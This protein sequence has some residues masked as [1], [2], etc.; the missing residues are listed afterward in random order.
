MTE[1]KKIAKNLF[2]LETAAIGAVVL[3]YGIILYYIKS[4]ISCDEGYYLMGYIKSQEL[5]PMA[6]DF[7]NMVRAIT[8]DGM[9]ENVLYFRYLRFFLDIASAL[10]FG[11]SSFYWLKKEKNFQ[12]SRFLYIPLII[13]SA[14]IGYT[15]TTATISFDHLQHIIYLFAFSAFLYADASGNKTIRIISLCIAGFFVVLG[16]TNYLP[17]GI[18]LLLVFVALI[19]I[20]RQNNSAISN[21]F[22]LFGGILIGF[23]IYHFFVTPVDVLVENIATSMKVAS[24][25]VTRHDSGS[26]FIQ[27]ILAL[28]TFLLIQIPSFG[29]GYVLGKK[30]INIKL[31]V[32]ITLVLIVAL[33]LVKKI[34]LLQGYLYYLP[35]SFTMGIWIAKK[36]LNKKNFKFT[37]L[38]LF[39][40]FTFLP[41][42]G[43]FGTN[44]SVMSKIMIFMPFW[45]CLFLVVIDSIK[46][47]TKSVNAIVLVVLVLFSFGYM[48]QGNLRR[49]HSYYTPRS[50]K[51]E[52]NSGVR[53]KKIKVSAYEQK[54]YSTFADT[55]VSIGFKPGETALAFGEQQ[56]GLY[57]IGGYFHGPLVYSINQYVK[58]PEQRV[59]Y[60][61]LFKKE[62]TAMEKQLENSGWNF[63]SDYQRI[64]MGTM[65]EN[66]DAANHNTVIYY[67]QEP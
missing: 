50:S 17:S 45:M 55:L 64:E 44:Q 28:S 58:I 61:L 35:V 57:L 60:I 22:I 40:I 43:V 23:V 1:I 30:D 19:V 41:F 21:I 66:I 14:S 26:L 13:L 5:G 20:F 8:P 63:P 51:Y 42:M 38:L 52:F 49:Y 36:R 59:K 54:Y 47:P 16:L 10:L 2:S 34:Y 37:E 33:L 31:I 4:G 39:L 46:L 12:L 24:D 11:L 27:M 18:L 9:Q 29:I 32:T 65:A 56:I 62:E 3:V 67:V 53:Y 25:G 7:H 15:Y 48:Y 6:N